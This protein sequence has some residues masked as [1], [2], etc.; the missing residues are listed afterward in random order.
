MIIGLTGTT[1][2]GKSTFI[3]DFINKFQR[4]SQPKDSYRS[5]P[6]LDLY[7]NGTEESQRKIR[8]F[9]FK[10]LKEIWAKRD[11]NKRVIVDRTLL[12]NL[13]C[14]LYLYAKND[15]TISDEFMEESFEITRKAMGMYHLIYFVPIEEIDNIEVPTTVDAD[16][17][18]GVDTFLKTIHTAFLHRDPLALDV[19]PN[20]GSTALDMITGDRE[21]RLEWASNILD[22]N[23]DVQGGFD[24]TDD[25]VLYDPDGREVNA[26]MTE[27]DISLKDFGFTDQEIK[28]QT[29]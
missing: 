27:D 7:E 1:K 22:E 23:G 3:K 5:I 14:T 29:V 16:F 12:D 25:P 6:D 8:D 17:R 24:T 9:M 18:L 13:A 4:Y 21:E 2:V 15:G 28:K 26:S 10:Q 20:K 19:F 11:T